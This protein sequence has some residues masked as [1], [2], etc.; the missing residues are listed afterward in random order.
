MQVVIGDH[1]DRSH[2]R[3]SSPS[4]NEALNKCLSKK[5]GSQ[6]GDMQSENTQQEQHS[7]RKNEGIPGTILQA[8][9]QPSLTLISQPGLVVK[10][11]PPQ[12]SFCETS[13]PTRASVHRKLQLSK[14]HGRTVLAPGA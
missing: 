13:W 11:V 9:L 4:D 2:D 3:F 5:S 1:S 6:E 7:K 10:T 8:I 12:S 14:V